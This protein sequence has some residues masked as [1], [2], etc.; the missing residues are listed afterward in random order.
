VTLQVHVRL[1]SSKY[2][3]NLYIL[4][5]YLVQS[6]FKDAIRMCA[7]FALW[8]F[9]SI[10]VLMM[11]DDTTRHTKYKAGPN[12]GYITVAVQTKHTIKRL[13]EVQNNNLNFMRFAP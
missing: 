9:G 12:L 13:P 1:F 7:T 3:L 6:L 8:V 5:Y 10:S 11:M 2:S 4:K